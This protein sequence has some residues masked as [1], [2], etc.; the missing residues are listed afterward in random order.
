MRKNP[1]PHSMLAME[2]SCPRASLCLR[3]DGQDIYTAE[4]VSE[5]SH[6]SRIF[7]F[8]KEAKP[9]LEAHPPEFIL[10]G[11]GPGSYSGIRVALAA[12]DGLALVY[13]S[14]VVAMPSW[15]ALPHEGK[16]ALVISDARRGGW[17]LAEFC[18][19]ALSESFRIVSAEEAD[20]AIRQAQGNGMLLLSCEEGKKLES[21]GWTGFR[22]GLVPSAQGILDSWTRK[23]HEEQLKLT[24]IPPSPL[25]LR[26]PHITP[27]KRAAWE[28]GRDAGK[29]KH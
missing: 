20:D 13:G 28:K 18:G 8:L 7:D 3:V 26:D 25:Y 16:N 24:A 6:N 11:S 14:R 29:I 17:A 22:F 2:T 1:P 12:A 10:V 27:A 9:F 15:E 19:G 23:S 21:K 4:W 5:R